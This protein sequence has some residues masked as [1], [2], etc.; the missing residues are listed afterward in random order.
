LA[1]FVKQ[2]RLTIYD[3]RLLNHERVPI[4]HVYKLG[5][6]HG[7]GF[8]GRALDFSP[9]RFPLFWHRRLR[10]K[11]TRPEKQKVPLRPECLELA[12]CV[13]VCLC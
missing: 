7:F 2:A 9:E 10:R 13:A 12:F 5:D 8:F 1:H 11:L 3:E 4:C 6:L